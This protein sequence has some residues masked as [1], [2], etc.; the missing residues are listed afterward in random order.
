M[1]EEEEFATILPSRELEWD[2]ASHVFK[3]RSRDSYVPP[4]L[5]KESEAIPSIDDFRLLTT[6]G[7][8]AFGKVRDTV[9][10]QPLPPATLPFRVFF[11]PFLPPLSSSHF[12]G[13]F[14]QV[15]MSV[16]I[17]TSTLCALKIV[18]KA[19]I[20]TPKQTRQILQELQIL[21]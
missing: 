2:S 10:F 18:P 13:A 3:L 14:V 8:G 12:L 21:K 5:P 4:L 20:S 16:H 17:A 9:A 7:K 19:K 6:V 15:V 1:N 11:F